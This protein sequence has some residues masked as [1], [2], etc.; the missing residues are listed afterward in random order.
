[1]QNNHPAAADTPGSF[2]TGATLSDRV[3]RNVDLEA[4][5]RIGQQVPDVV[6][7]EIPNAVELH[8][9]LG[10]FTQPKPIELDE[11][12]TVEVMEMSELRLGRR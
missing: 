5:P 10:L 8:D 7:E 1:M 4:S 6:L 11:Q 2:F 9:V 3:H 12:I